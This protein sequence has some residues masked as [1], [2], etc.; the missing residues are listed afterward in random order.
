MAREFSLN[1][2]QSKRD[3]AS[4]QLDNPLLEL[5]EEDE[6]SSALHTTQRTN[7]FNMAARMIKG[8]NIV[9]QTS[10]INPSALSILEHLGTKST[11]LNSTFRA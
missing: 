11:I 3:V 4:S 7:T 8:Q 5:N 9:T 6:D 2:I 1:M 10:S